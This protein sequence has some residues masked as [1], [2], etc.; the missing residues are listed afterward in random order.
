MY[1]IRYPWWFTCCT[2]SGDDVIIVST[3][4]DDT[5]VQITAGP[6]SSTPS[7]SESSASDSSADDAKT[8]EVGGRRSSMNDLCHATVCIAQCSIEWRFSM[9]AVCQYC[10]QSV[11]H[12][13]R[14]SLWC[15][16][17]EENVVAA[18][19]NVISWMTR[20]ATTSTSKLKP[21]KS[22]HQVL[23]THES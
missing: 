6:N 14:S 3:K 5:T 22:P 9:R 15:G 17:V 11:V 1:K 19:G 18:R 8:T 12:G 13:A 16:I 21:P 2:F 7:P 23:T 4:T 10:T 20:L